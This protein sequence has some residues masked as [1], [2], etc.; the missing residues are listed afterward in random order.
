MKK[1]FDPIIFDIY[2]ELTSTVISILSKELKYKFIKKY[3]F[4]LY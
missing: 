3:K 1:K 4:S 2:S